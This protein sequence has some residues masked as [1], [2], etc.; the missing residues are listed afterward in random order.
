MDTVKDPLGARVVWDSEISQA[1]RQAALGVP[2]F[3]NITVI[4][5]QFKESFPLNFTK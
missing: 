2:S 1:R 5:E 3:R 4:C